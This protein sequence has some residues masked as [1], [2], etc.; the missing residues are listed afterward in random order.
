MEK[1]LKTENI[2]WDLSCMYAGLDDPRIDVDVAELVR[3]AERFNVA[4]KGKL[5]ETLGKAIADYAAMG[6]LSNKIMVFLYLTQSKDT[7]DGKVKA[8][9]ADV[10]RILNQSS[11]E[12]MTFFTI[13]LVALPD[14]VLEG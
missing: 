7:T 4:Y 12:N 14:S 9:I 8:K 6:M 2:N 10:E 11:A 3:M 13:E 5:A 1:N